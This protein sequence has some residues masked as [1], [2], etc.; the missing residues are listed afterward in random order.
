MVKPAVEQ[1]GMPPL[2]AAA[3]PKLSAQRY[4]SLQAD[5][6]FQA[7]DRSPLDLPPPSTH[8]REG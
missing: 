7:R 6:A 5:P 1:E 8:G 2:I 3:L 4:R